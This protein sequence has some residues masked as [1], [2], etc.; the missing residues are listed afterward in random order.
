MSVILALLVAIAAAGVA[1]VRSPGDSNPP[2]S[3]RNGRL[4]EE[5]RWDVIHAYKKRGSA[6][7][8]AK[9]AGVNV[10]A[11]RRWIER[12]KKTSSVKSG[13]ST[14]RPRVLTA[15]AQDAA[16]DL[17]IG[18][19]AKTAK[20]VARILYSKGIT[21]KVVSANTIIR[22]A[23][24]A[25]ARRGDKVQ[26]ERGDPPKALTWATIQ[27]RIE[28]CKKH[29]SFN[30]RACMFTDR[31]RFLYKFPG[32]AVSKWRWVLKGAPRQGVHSPNHPQCV[33]VYAGI[34]AF[35]ATICH[36]VA[37]T[38]KHKTTYTN[39]QGRTA[40]N[41]TAQEY[42]DVLTKTLLPEGRRI[43][44]SQGISTWTFQQDNDPS[45][46]QAGA[47]IKEW[48]SKQSASV[49]LLCNWPPNSPDLNPIENLWAAVSAKLDA[50]GC[51]TFEEFKVA[52]EQTVKEEGRKL[53]PALVK[54]MAKRV[55]DC[56]AAEGGKINY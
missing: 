7:L 29:L 14:G 53:G 49:Q 1:A 31:K 52:V 21:D 45:H 27:K 22:G 50:M 9:D 48:N 41:I 35:G 47:V 3:S 8:A 56:L 16:L 34:T 25:A 32:Q 44:S 28:F 17:L 12:W 54:S 23:K 38:S 51:K 40:S 15:A 11:A 39:K 42:A 5:Q 43:F 18:K 2:K 13:S 30:W 10:R 36:V 4:T 24:E 26:V 55:R 46:K 20:D 19:P 33:N 37:G 6:P